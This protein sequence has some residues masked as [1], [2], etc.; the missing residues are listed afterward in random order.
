MGGEKSVGNMSKENLHVLL[1][2]IA[3]LGEAEIVDMASMI[4]NVIK[5]Y[6]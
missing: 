4:G 6:E 3:D 1:Q 2:V 5:H